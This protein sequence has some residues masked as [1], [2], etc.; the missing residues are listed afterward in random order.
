M[1][2]VYGG[3]GFYELLDGAEETEYET[4]YGPPSAPITTG[5]IEGTAVAFLPRH[6]RNHEFP[7]HHIP[8]RANAWAMRRIGVTRIVAPSAVG[9]IH[10][11][12]APGHF[13][14]PDQLV[15][16]TWGRGHT[17]FD[18]PGVHHI[19]FADPYCPELRPLAVQ[20]IA[21]A[22][23]TGHDGGTTVVVQGPRFSTRAESA[24]FASN[25]WHLLNMTQIPEA[26]LARELGLCYVNIA[27]VT[28]YD[29]GVPGEV[30]PVT[31]D[32]VLARF[33]ESLETLREIL[34]LLVPAA[35]H[36]PRDCGC[37]SAAPAEG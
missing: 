17:F 10:P 19:A 22:G 12:Y 33:A 13:V 7:P 14:V 27:V 29:V 5:E 6:G 30:A 4:P 35:A 18:G 20:A 37:A 11:E 34:R 1:I 28:D 32:E 16:R 9:S 15:D 2:G 8:Y 26:S 25:G 21:G 23:A 24:W 3:S 36:A 31:H